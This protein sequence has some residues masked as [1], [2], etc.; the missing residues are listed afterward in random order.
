MA[1]R[2]A[3]HEANKRCIHLFIAVALRWQ[4]VFEEKGVVDEL[5]T[6]QHPKDSKTTVSDQCVTLR[7]NSLR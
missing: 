7:M 2:A 6:L 4:D 5:L 3:D 1:A